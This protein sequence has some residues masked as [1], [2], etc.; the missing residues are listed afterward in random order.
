MSE[1][2]IIDDYLLSPDNLYGELYKEVQLKYIF[3]DT[4]TFVDCV[5]KIPPEE[6]VK[7]YQEKKN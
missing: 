5:Q 4:K 7:L 1:T 2:N 3:S 6:I